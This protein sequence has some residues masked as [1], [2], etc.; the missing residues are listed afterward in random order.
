M[1]LLLLFELL[2]T[3]EQRVDAQND[4]ESQ[5]EHYAPDAAAPTSFMEKELQ[6]HYQEKSMGAG[7][8]QWVDMCF[9]SVALTLVAMLRKVRY[10]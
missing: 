9:T 5:D 7:R 8:I 2:K 10:G 6:K 3:L 1:T 4:E